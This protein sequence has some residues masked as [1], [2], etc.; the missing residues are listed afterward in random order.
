MMRSLNNTPMD[1]YVTSENYI[2]H[3]I[4]CR[5]IRTLSIDPRGEEPRTKKI[6]VCGNYLINAMVL[7][8]AA[9]F[10]SNVIQR[11]GLPLII[12]TTGSC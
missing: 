4:V 12:T 6:R 3:H 2:R 8:A 1:Y 11:H 7:R 5:Y 9:C 10:F